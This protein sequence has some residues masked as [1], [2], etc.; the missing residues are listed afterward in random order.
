MRVVAKTYPAVGPFQTQGPLGFFFAAGV[1][2]SITAI[3]I[4]LGVVT[5]AVAYTPN[6]H[7]ERGTALMV[8]AIGAAAAG[9]V[10]IAAVRTITGSAI[11]ASFAMAVVFTAGQLV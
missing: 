5:Y 6:C 3:L 1:T 2:L 4:S 10:T 7:S 8:G 9:C 11:A